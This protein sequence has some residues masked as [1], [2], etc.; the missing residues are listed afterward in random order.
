MKFYIAK[1]HKEFFDRQGL[2]EFDGLFSDEAL[3]QFN[4]TVDDALRVKMEIPKGRIPH[5]TSDQL[6]VQGRDLW[7]YQTELRKIVF[8]TKLAEIASQLIDKKPLRI[9]Y[10]QL[11]PARYQQAS[12][13]PQ[14]TLLKPVYTPF[15]EQ[16]TT[17]ETIS[18]IQGV[19]CGVM[20]AL[21]SPD[22]EPQS[23]V[24]EESHEKKVDVFSFTKGNAIFFHPETRIDLSAFNSHPGQRY[25]MIV[26]AQPTSF[27]QLQPA[28]PQ[29][30]D[31]KQLG[32]IFNDRLSDKMHPIIYR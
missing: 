17:L 9:G 18:C 20:I 19:L 24:N 6:F 13:L 8:Q 10:D 25:Y 23:P 26:Y 11:F 12:F 5:L 29:T 4:Q 16:I 28:D 21:T 32:Y 1:E 30:H 2:I 7:R 3:H 22:E 27:Y 31:L 15:L 14:K